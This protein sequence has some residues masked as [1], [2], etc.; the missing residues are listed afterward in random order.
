MRPNGHQEREPTPPAKK[1]SSHFDKFVSRL[2]AVPH[3]EIKQQLDAEREAKRTSKTS[4]RVSD[5]SSN[6]D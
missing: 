5:A 4:S 1:E 6:Q 2:L 3:S